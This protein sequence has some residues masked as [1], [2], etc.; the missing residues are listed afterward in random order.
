MSLLEAVA[1]PEG[2]LIRETIRN[3]PKNSSALIYQFELMA[4]VSDPVRDV[5]RFY[6]LGLTLANPDTHEP[7]TDQFVRLRK[8]DNGHYGVEI[9]ASQQWRVQLKDLVKAEE[10][11]IPIKWYQTFDP[12]NPNILSQPTYLASAPEQRDRLT[13]S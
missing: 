6:V 12:G 2:H 10:D 7:F 8:D 13:G 11:L 9:L 1:V 4:I 5:P 3:M